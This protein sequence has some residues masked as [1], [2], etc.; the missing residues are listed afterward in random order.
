MP[1]P[2][3]QG[4][5]E[6]AWEVTPDKAAVIGPT[7]VCTGELTGDEDIV[8]KGTFRGKIHLPKHSLFIEAGAR[9]E[10]DIAAVNVMLRGN[11]TG[12]IRATGKILVSSAARMNGDIAAARVS[13]Q[14]GAQFKGSIKIMK[15]DA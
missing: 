1:K 12:S 10:A 5:A 15:G 8:I 7:V 3:D 14:D 13:V 11:L 9:I 4:Q 6:K 2:E